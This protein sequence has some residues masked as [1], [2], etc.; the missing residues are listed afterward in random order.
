[1]ELRYEGTFRRRYLVGTSAERDR[2]GGQRQRRVL[3]S[4]TV[5][6]GDEP[7]VVAD[8]G[9]QGVAKREEAKDLA[10]T[11]HFAMCRGKRRALDASRERGRLPE[12]L[13]KLM[14]SIRAKVKHPL[15]VIEQQFGLV[16]VRY[17]GLAKSKAWVT[18]L[19]RLA[20]CGWCAGKS[21]ENWV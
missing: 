14:G 11:W 5:F 9:Y 15:R 20:N 6:T 8:A 3:G 21:W 16:K 17:R 7:D 13:E 4:G 18:M 12:K 10:V 1:M 2:H 19:L